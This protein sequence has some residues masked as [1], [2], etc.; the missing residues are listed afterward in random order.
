M[1]L[2]KTLSIVA[3]LTQ[4]RPT[5]TF[6]FL[7]EDRLSDTH[8]FRK[9]SN[10]EASCHYQ[11][12]EETHETVSRW[13]H[14]CRIVHVAL[15]DLWRSNSLRS[16][17]SLPFEDGVV[18]RATNFCNSEMIQQSTR[19]RALGHFK[20]S[21]TNNIAAGTRKFVRNLVSYYVPTTFIYY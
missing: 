17:F 13:S 5:L 2:N 12:S 20:P 16:Q 11:E 14:I 3:E 1:R 9:K 8:S 10:R 19:S 4:K 21:R 7:R 15:S 6:D 18:C